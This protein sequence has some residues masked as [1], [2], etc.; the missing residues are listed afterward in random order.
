ML[1]VGVR[2]RLRVGGHHPGLGL[3]AARRLVGNR[4]RGRPAVLPGHRPGSSILLGYDDSLDAFGVHGIGGIVGALLTGAYVYGPLTADKDHPNGIYIGGLEQL[5]HQA[6]AVA[7][8][9][10]YT[11]VATLVILVVVGLALGLRVNTEEE[12]EGLD[13]ALHG[14]SLG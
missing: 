12:R 11:A 2:V 6:V 10:M 9:I 1:G 13:I 7:A 14:E 3:R 4:R 5:G 8:T